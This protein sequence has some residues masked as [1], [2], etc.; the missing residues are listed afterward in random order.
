MAVSR[1]E[2]DAEI[3]ATHEVMRQLRPDVAAER[4]VAT[5][6]RMMASDGYRLVARL[7]EGNVR[8]VAGYRIMEMLH[9][10]RILYVDDL[11]TDERTRSQ[12]HGKRLLDWLKDEAR[13]RGCAELHLDS[14][15]HREHAHRFYFREG[16]TV[17]SFH[18][19]IPV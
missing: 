3:L 12:G 4:Y 13:A 7:V 15:L 11:I 17:R 6:R 16:L 9:C 2:T 8:A 19:R 1:M 14:G 10:G 18:F 5:V